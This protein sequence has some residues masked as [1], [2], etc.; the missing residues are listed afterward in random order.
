MRPRH[1]V[2]PFG[3][4]RT[5][6]IEMACVLLPLMGFR[7]RQQVAVR[8]A[9]GS[10]LVI[11]ER[12]RMPPLANRDFLH[13]S[14]GIEAPSLDVGSHRLPD[15]SRRAGTVFLAPEMDVLRISKARGVDMIQSEREERHLVRSDEPPVI[16]TPPQSEEALGLDLRRSDCGP[17]AARACAKGAGRVQELSSRYSHADFAKRPSKMIVRSGFS[18]YAVYIAPWIPRPV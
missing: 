10:V 1:I 2:R 4:F 5:S 15:P 3:P 6:E 14:D 9:E 17:S 12:S 8:H 13:P 11:G 18:D 16:G 7:E